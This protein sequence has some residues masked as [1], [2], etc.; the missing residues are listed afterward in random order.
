MNNGAGKRVRAMTV[1]AFG[2]CVTLV[3]LLI[4]NRDYPF[5]GHD[6]AYFIPR[7]LDT[8]LHTRVN[9]LII[10]WYTPGFGGGLPAFP[11]PQHLQYSIVQWLTLLIDPWAA[12]LVSTAILSLAGYSFYYRFLYEKL[13]LDWRASTLGAMFFIGNGFY[14]EHLIAGQLG[15]QLFPLSAI[16]L[17]ALTDRSRRPVFNGA[18]VAIVGTLIVYQAGFYLIV[19]L[20]LSLGVT[21][22]LIYFYRPRL[23]EPGTL[24]QTGLITMIL[25]AGMA[26]SKIHAA[27]AFLGNFP[28]EAYDTY[29]V[30]ILQGLAGVVAQ[31]LGVLNLAPILSATGN[32]PELI[33]GILAQITG[34][35][36]GIWETDTGLSPILVILLIACFVSA[37]PAIARN[38]IQLNRSQLLSLAMLVAGVWITLEFS[39]AKGILYASTKPLPILRSLH[40]NVRFVSAFIIPLVLIGSFLS[41]KFVV[42]SERLGAFSI[43]AVLTLLSLLSYFLLSAPIH[44]R[45]FDAGSASRIYWNIRNGNLSPV[46]S[47]ADVDVWQGF[48][49]GKSSIKPYEPIFGYKLEAFEPQV[50]LGSVLEAGDGHYN[51]TNPASL[52][53]PE[54]NNTHPF[55]RIKVEEMDKLQAFMQHRQPE[56]KMPLAQTLLNIVSTAAFVIT[57]ATALITARFNPANH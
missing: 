36:Y 11:N 16:V 15:Y 57:L 34:A 12:V 4:M 37:V 48:A 46:T 45:Y 43:G 28:R 3:I 8:D 7:L 38:R 18:R 17:D 30:G 27:L 25:F 31:L 6:Y 53:F 51:M 10:Q 42:R 50:H 5:V 29:N 35:E 14:I 22:P 56:W 40:V 13:E 24:F 32:N 19:I 49:E 41:H 21:L 39:L 20:L 33:T 55:E 26:A 44:Q 23:Y 52:V 9:G 1:P 2:G 47:I 54:S